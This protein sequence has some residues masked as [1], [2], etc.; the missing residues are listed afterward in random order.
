[1]S[2]KNEL[3]TLGPTNDLIEKNKSSVPVTG[4]GTKRNLDLTKY[5]LELIALSETANREDPDSLWKSFLAYV[6]ICIKYNVRVGNMGAYTALGIDRTTAGSWARGEQRK[7]DPRYK[8]LILKIKAVCG[9]FRE[10]AMSENSK[11]ALNPLV[12]IWWQ[13]NY[14]G[15]SNDPREYLGGPEDDDFIDLEE[16]KA[17]YA[18]LPDD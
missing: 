8:E 12:G 13:K 16:I 1:M 17:K 7:D 11:D 5:T 9:S 4:N 6:E 15:L 18:D 3:A 14:D 2:K 10:A